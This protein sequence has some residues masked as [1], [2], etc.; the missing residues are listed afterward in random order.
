M[1]NLLIS[2]IAF[3]PL[4]S[5]AQSFPETPWLQNGEIQV[6]V[7][8][9]A[10]RGGYVGFVAR[11][12]PYVQYFIKDRWSLR[13]EGEYETYQLTR[14]RDQMAGRT[15]GFG[16]GVSTQYYFLQRDRFALYGKVGYNYGKTTNNVYNPIDPTGPPTKTFRSNYNRVSLG[17]GAQYRLGERW[18]INGLI[19]QQSSYSLK[20]NSTNVNIGVGFRIR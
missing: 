20:N 5:S 19:E 15:Q 18:L 12:T 3:F 2:I 14:K 8:V 7:G 10:A 1:K 16:I 17:V 6:G 9:G 13:L 11:T 4:C